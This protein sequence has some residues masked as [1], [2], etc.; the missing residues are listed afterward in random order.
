MCGGVMKKWKYT[1]TVMKEGNNERKWLWR[2]NERN[3][4][5][6][7]WENDEENMTYQLIEGV[8]IFVNI[9][10]PVSDWPMIR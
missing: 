4:M 8:S 10:Q 6:W 9:I 5:I 7:K 2:I 3:D 1:M